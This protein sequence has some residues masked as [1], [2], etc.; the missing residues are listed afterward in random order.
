MESA[1]TTDAPTPWRPP[2]T[3]YPPPP[4]LPPAW[5]IVNTTSTAGIPAFS[6]IPTGIPLP[7]SITVIELSPLIET[8]ISV[9]NPAKASSIALST[10]SYTR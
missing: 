9:Q 4:N 1:L 8:F 7:L 5:R 10:I 2:E 6:C 3:L